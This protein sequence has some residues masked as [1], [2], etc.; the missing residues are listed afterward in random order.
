[1]MCKNRTL[2]AVFMTLTIVLFV[3]CLSFATTAW[4]GKNTPWEGTDEQYLDI[5]N[6]RL[7]K[8]YSAVLKK[9]LPIHGAEA[10]ES[11]AEV[12]AWAKGSI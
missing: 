7:L 12:S 6:H 5:Y 2:I 11:A 1:M 8:H 9:G 3:N 10:A 4:K